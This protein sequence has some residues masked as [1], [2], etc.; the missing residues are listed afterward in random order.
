MKKFSALLSSAVI[1]IVQESTRL[2]ICFLLSQFQSE[3]LQILV[4]LGVKKRSFEG[5]PVTL[6]KQPLVEYLLS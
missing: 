5:L 2:T 4:Y 1:H 3:E 6:M